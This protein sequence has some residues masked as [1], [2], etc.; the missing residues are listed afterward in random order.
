MASV[1]VALGGGEAASAACQ[2]QQTAQFKVV[3]DGNEPLIDGSINHHAIR[4]MLDTGAG[5]TMISSRAAADLGLRVQVLTGV[6]TYGVGGGDRT[7]E[8]TIQT[9]QVGDAVAHNIV[10]LVSGRGLRS[11]RFAGFLGEE[12]L[13]RSD[14]ELD[15]ANGVVRMIRP[16]D[17]TG[18]EVAYWAKNYAVAP[19][20]PS[21]ANQAPQVY[22]MLNGQRILAVM[23]TGASTSV[24]DAGAAASVGVT[25]HSEGVRQ[26]GQT[27][28]IAGKLISTSVAVFPTFSIG[29]ETIKNAKLKIADLFSADAE[30]ELGSRVPQK[31]MSFPQMLLGADFIRAHHIYVARSQGRVYMS[32]N[33]GPIFQVTGPPADEA[34]AEETAKARP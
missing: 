21:S 1:A 26:S 15:F 32:Y 9:L 6:T 19:L 20:A 23:D 29:E 25:P 2:L 4:F 7:G 30:V 31:V 3:M 22:V 28:G 18:D 34:G 24:V 5:S 11:S 13:S 14:L 10:L 17:C 33:G 27:A 12:L 16:K 8:A